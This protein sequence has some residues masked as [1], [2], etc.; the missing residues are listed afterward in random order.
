[1]R[2]IMEYFVFWLFFF[3]SLEVNILV[4]LKY[5]EVLKRKYKKEEMSNLSLSRKRI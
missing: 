5:Y 2:I 1:M 4:L 3:V